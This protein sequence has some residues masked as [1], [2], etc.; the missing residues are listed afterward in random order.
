MK[1]SSLSYLII[2]NKDSRTCNNVSF[3]ELKGYKVVPKKPVVRSDMIKVNHMNVINPALI[4]KLLRKK[5]EKKIEMLIFRIV[6]VMDSDDDDDAMKAL[7]E[8]ERI[9]YILVH[10]YANFLEE[11]Y[12]K[13]MSRKLEI[14]VDELRVRMMLR[15]QYQDVKEE[16]R[17][18]SR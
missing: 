12:I 17:G 15:Y 10:E 1:N 5:T 16:T 9:K 11:E 3:K 6:N 18:K 2:K 8:A 4:E 7:T 14:I 13:K